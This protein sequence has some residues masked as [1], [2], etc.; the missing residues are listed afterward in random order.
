MRRNRTKSRKKNKSNNILVILAFII[1]LP[2]VSISIGYFGVKYFIVPKFLSTNTY[3][4]NKKE[5][6]VGG[7]GNEDS[8]SRIEENTQQSNGGQEKAQTNVNKQAEKKPYTFELPPLSILNIQVGSFSD[9]DYAQAQ[10]KQLHDKGLEGYVVKSNDKYKVMVMSFLDRQNAEKYSEKIREYYS[11][12]FISPINIPVRSIS[13]GESDKAYAE[14]A[15]KGI[16]NLMKFY[17]S[18]SDFLLEN[19]LAK[20]DSRK[21][22]EF[23]DSE[24]KKLDAIKDAISKISPSDDFSKFNKNLT[25]I[26]ENSRTEL[27]TLKK[28]GISKKETLWEIYMESLN[29]YADII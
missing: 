28:S 4:E 23:I 2:A 5:N 21:L 7:Q 13:Y 8:E 24:V 15:S 11:D 26:V 1:L 16:N 19:D 25:I 27:E 20:I 17:K 12:A 3:V 9:M 22:N 29:S 10:I 6:K 18:Y 14:A